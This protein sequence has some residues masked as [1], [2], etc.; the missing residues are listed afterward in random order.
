[1][2]SQDEALEAPGGVKRKHT[3]FLY[4]ICNRSKT[5]SRHI[6]LLAPWG[7]SAAR[8][9]KLLFLNIQQVRGEAAAVPPHIIGLHLEVRGSCP[10]A[11]W[12]VRGR[13]GRRNTI[14][15]S[16]LSLPS[17][18][19]RGSGR[20]LAWCVTINRRRRRRP[21]SSVSP[22]LC[23]KTGSGW[24]VGEVR[25]CCMWLMQISPPAAA[26]PLTFPGLDLPTDHHRSSA[27]WIMMN[28]PSPSSSANLK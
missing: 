11:S 1:M 17:H 22:C 6:A 12:H 4:F 7:T 23:L 24:H 5:K 21:H 15:V 18:A 27:G 16:L 28:C 9:R 20:L 3:G 2:K 13:Q 26:R 19:G 10:V 8:A 25:V 14:S